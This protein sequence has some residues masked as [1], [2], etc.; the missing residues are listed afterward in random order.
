ML[1][2]NR[3]R[4]SLHYGVVAKSLLACLYVAAVGVTFVWYKNQIHR[5][6]DEIKKRENTL[7]AVEKR[8]AMLM[9]QLAQ[10]KSPAYLE[11][12]CQEC[13]IQ[14]VSPRESQMVRVYEP[15]AAWEAQLVRSIWAERSTTG[16]PRNL[17]ARQ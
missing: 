17:V 3:K 10:L 8:N 2:R 12:R 4:A 14:L 7:A 13:G 16:G 15:T 6:G 5:L 11:A 9:T 1:Q